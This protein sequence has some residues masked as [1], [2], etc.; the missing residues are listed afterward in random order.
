MSVAWSFTFYAL[1]LT[2]SGYV[3]TPYV[4]LYEDMLEIQLPP[5]RKA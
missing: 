1:R 3:L 5:V 2:G 4:T